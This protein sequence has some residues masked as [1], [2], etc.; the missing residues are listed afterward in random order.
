MPDFIF[1]GFYAREGDRETLR[2]NIFFLPLKILLKNAFLI[3]KFNLLKIKDLFFFSKEKD[4]RQNLTVF[5]FS[6]YKFFCFINIKVRFFLLFS[7]FFLAPYLIN[8]FLYKIFFTSFYA[9]KVYFCVD[10]SREKS[11][12]LFFCFEL[13]HMEQKVSFFCLHPLFFWFNFNNLVLLTF[14]V[15]L[16]SVNVVGAPALRLFL[17]TVKTQR[18]FKEK[19]FRLYL[20]LQ[21]FF[22]F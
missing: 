20:F 1:F 19:F 13:F 17:S 16:S 6:R 9:L 18:F 21:F 22:V 2:Q 10:F 5:F 11:F 15:E 7:L 14:H 3:K 12:F 8:V 4:F